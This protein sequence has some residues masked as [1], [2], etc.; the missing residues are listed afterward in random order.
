M[1]IIE[2]AV[3]AYDVPLLQ[4]FKS[5]DIPT[6]TYYRTIHGKTELRYD[7]ARKVMKAIEKLHALKAARDY[8]EQ[9]RSSGQR[10]N[11]SQTRA[12]FKPRSFGS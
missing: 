5:A 11:I 8:T 4:A 2:E 6:S 7:T 9:L 1:Q 12:K 3:E 10:V